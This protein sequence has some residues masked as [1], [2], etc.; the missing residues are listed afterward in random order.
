MSQNEK[1]SIETDADDLALL[2]EMSQLKSRQ[3]RILR[4]NNDQ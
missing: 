3:V 4:K 2:N 1:T